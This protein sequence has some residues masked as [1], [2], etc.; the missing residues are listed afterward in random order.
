[1]PVTSND[2][3]Y[4][5]ADPQDM[6]FT[7][8]DD[9]ISTS[10][11]KFIIT[12]P[13]NATTLDDGITSTFTIKLNIAP[14]STVSIP[15]YVSDSTEALLTSGTS[16]NVD[17]L[18][19][20]FTSSDWSTPQTVTVTGQGPDDD[21]ETAYSVILMP[22]V[23]SDSNFNGVNP[24]DL[25]FIN[26]SPI[27]NVLYRSIANNLT[28]DLGGKAG[29]DAMCNSE[30]PS[31]FSAGYAFASFDA[32]N[33]I[34][35]LPTTAGIDTNLSIRSLTNKLIATNWTDLL[36]GNITQSLNAAGMGPTSVSVTPYWRSFSN[37]DGSL[38]SDNC[39]G[40]TSTTNNHKSTVGA[41]NS[42]SNW[43]NNVTNTSCSYDTARYILCLAK[44]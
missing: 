32:N 30:R 5:G 20:T 41:F 27:H 35:D 42:D 28:G 12:A 14:T 18:T 2:T 9:E 1:M 43:I 34:R 22:V 7:N 37:D 6:A 31:G 26:S 3:N 38:N 39:N 10:L 15:V 40:G 23:S 4:N 21:K 29:A 36:D 13:D 16:S 19:L 24:Q 33:E 8:L 11:G 25:N 44:P 17:N